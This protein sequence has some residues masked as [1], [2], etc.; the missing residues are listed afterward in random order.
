M[1]IPNTRHDIEKEIQ[2]WV[3]QKYNKTINYKLIVEKLE[4]FILLILEF[5]SSMDDHEMESPK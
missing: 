5:I 1:L 4:N 3:G 2:T